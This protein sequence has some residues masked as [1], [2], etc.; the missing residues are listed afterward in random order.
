[1]LEL[2]RIGDD[3]YC[4]DVKL[5]ICKQSTK[6][7]GKEV[8]KIDGLLGSN[9]KKWLSLS[10][11]VEGVN[12]FND[13]DLQPKNV[14]IKNY[15][16][17]PEE[18]VE[19]EKLNGEIEILQD[20]ISEII[21]IAKSRYVPSIKEKKKQKSINKMNSEELKEYIAYCTKLLNNRVQ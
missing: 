13:N 7:E 15:E 6:G 5:Y 21:E 3:V 19:I 8:V 2:K 1:M 11:L 20:K 17:T 10:K 14:G 18:E 9:G 4:G 16:L 12:V